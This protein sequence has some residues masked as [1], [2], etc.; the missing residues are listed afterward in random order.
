MNPKLEYG[1]FY[2]KK[3]RRLEDLTLEELRDKVFEI[4]K[5]QKYIADCG[6]SEEI[7]L[8]AIKE[9]DEQKQELKEIMH[10]KVDKL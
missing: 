4:T 6:L 7:T 8:L 3:E 2:C 1:C 5:K 9:L 10:K